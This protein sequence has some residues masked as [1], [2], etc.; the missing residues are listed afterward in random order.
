MGF[1]AAV[2][3]DEEPQSLA[4]LP[5]NSQAKD[6]LQYGAAVSRQPT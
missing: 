2:R 1:D 4:L 6:V 3:G 5:R